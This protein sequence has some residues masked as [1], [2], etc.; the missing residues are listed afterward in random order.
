MKR[1]VV[2]AVALGSLSDQ[3]LESGVESGSRWGI[4][5][6]VGSAEN[7]L[8]VR[9]FFD[10]PPVLME[11]PVVIAAEEDQIGQIGGPS[12]GP[13]FSVMAMDEIPGATAGETTT[14]IPMPELTT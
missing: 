1:A 13:V 7:G 3:F 2:G 11:K 5:L 4:D 9:V 8:L 6:P 12:V 10:P 14:A